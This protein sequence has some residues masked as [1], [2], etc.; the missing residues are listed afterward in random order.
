[1]RG[2]REAR[3]KEWGGRRRSG[4]GGVGKTG[5]GPWSVKTEHKATQSTQLSC[6]S[7]II[8]VLVLNSSWRTDKSG[9]SISVHGVRLPCTP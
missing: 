2:G 5:Q 7:P 9:K 4:G 6:D 3:R 1:M 8:L